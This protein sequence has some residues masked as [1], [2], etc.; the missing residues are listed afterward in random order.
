M[1]MERVRVRVRA[2]GTTGAPHPDAKALAEPL[3][4]EFEDRHL[5]VKM[6]KV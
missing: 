1:E 5:I 2:R 6:P 4:H 3:M